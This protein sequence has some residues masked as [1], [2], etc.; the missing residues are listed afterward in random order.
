MLATKRP[1][2]MPARSVSKGMVQGW[3]PTHSPRRTEEP[4]R[5]CFGHRVEDRLQAPH[6][7]AADSQ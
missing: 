7:C 2:S 4:L 5:L 6:A 1:G 3:A